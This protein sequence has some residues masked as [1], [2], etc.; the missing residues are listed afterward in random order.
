MTTGETD[1]S[2]SR[3]R[4]RMSGLMLRKTALLLAGSIVVMMT[5]PGSPATAQDPPSSDVLVDLNK[6]IYFY[7]QDEPDGYEQAIN[8]FTA[9]LERDSRNEAALL[10]RSLTYGQLGLLERDAQDTPRSQISDYR[11]VQKLRD[12]PERLAEMRTE[13]SD[14][15]AAGTATEDQGERHVLDRRASSLERILDNYELVGELSSEE[16]SARIEEQFEELHA[17]EARERELYVQMTDDLEVLLDKPETVIRLLNVIAE[18][19]IAGLKEA[20]AVRVMGGD[21][22]AGQASASVPVL[23]AS[24][25]DILRRT[26]KSLE[27]LRTELSAD[28]STQNEV[29]VGFFLGV[30]RYRQAV[31]RRAAE[32]RPEIDFHL[33]EQ[34]EEIMVSLADDPNVDTNWR[35]YAALYLGLILPFKAGQEADVAQRG[36]ILD[37][38][39]R[40]LSQAATLDVVVGEPPSSASFFAIPEVVWRQREQIEDVR[41]QPAA[42][43]QK[44]NDIQL[45]FLFGPSY[46]TNV[47]LLGGN[48]RI[49]RGIT[50]ET[51]FGFSV[52]TAI[53]YTLTL[54]ERWTLGVQARTSHIWHGE[55]TEFDEH[56]YGGSAA[57][58]YEA[59]RGDDAFGPVFLRLQYDYDYTLLDHDPFVGTHRFTP[60][61]RAFWA[62]QRAETNLY[63]RY[64]DRDYFEELFSQR[65]DRDGN[66]F[67]F[68]FIQSYDLVDMT[69]KYEQIGGEPWGH[70][71][72]AEFAQDNPDY[73]ARYLTPF[74]GFE[75]SYDS[76]HGTEYDNKGYSLRGGVLVPLPYGIDFDVAADW[77]WE[78]YENPSIIDFHRRGRRDFV[79]QYDVGLSRSFI[80]RGGKTVNRYRPDFDRVVMTLRA[81]ATFWDDD[82]NV[83]DRSGGEVFSYDRTLIGLTVAFAF[84]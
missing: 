26:T 5:V 40:R 67:G 21:I 15:R 14:V 31:P 64:E 84:N 6:G 41:T 20:E 37:E 23:R 45:S 9:V 44:I 36:T 19:K 75:Y 63:F 4:T 59:F 60:N 34:A 42:A 78:E 30:L 46:D 28:L 27:A 3:I 65:L 1:T 32:E 16:L 69:A 66:Y 29:R 11:E 52:G 17:S 62:E 35:S 61:L 50:D 58:Q 39:L 56:R 55:I 22:D 8:L 2:V 24:A 83:V 33:L 76:T 53:D 47:P 48:V 38:A 51:D 80:L 57:L 18:S 72:D 7:L 71:N 10:F 74:I 49:P 12:D 79:Q 13:I 43:A 25:E 54:T 68:G 70:P 81:F 73:P 77:R 82:S